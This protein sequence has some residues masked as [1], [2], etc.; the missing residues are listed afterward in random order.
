MAAANRTRIELTGRGLLHLADVASPAAPPE[1]NRP[2]TATD[3]QAQTSAGQAV[4]IP[5]LANDTDG[6][7]DPLSLIG[8]GAAAH[9]L[10]ELVGNEVRYT[11]DA[12]FTGSDGFSYTV[13]DGQLSATA[14]VAL[15][16]TAP[17]T[18]D[19]LV[20]NDDSA[21]AQSGAAVDIAVLA[22][23]VG[24]SGVTLT[25]SAVTAPAHGQ[26]VITGDKVRYTP[27]ANFAGTDTFTYTVNASD[28]QVAQ[29]LVSVEVT[30]QPTNGDPMVVDDG[31][32]TNQD[33]P[34]TIDLLANDSDP[35]GDPLIVTRVNQGS[36]GTVQWWRDGRVT[37][38][39]YPGVSGTDRF[40]YNVWDGND[41]Q[42]AG[43]VTIIIQPTDGA[44]VAVDDG[45]T[46]SA[47]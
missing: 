43:E 19:P 4:T 17:P 37:Y 44:P 35:E 13:S 2:P 27:D 8:V 21:S 16:V 20:L 36:L 3:D 41:G 45:T 46:S 30:I 26:A 9:G 47:G 40:D 7:G 39:P 5:V 28:G 1:T 11:P 10:T 31:A 33:M 6:D 24:P 18:I 38:T 25:L 29:A 14:S 15:T 23:D 22:N 42:A 32:T 34:V 12:G